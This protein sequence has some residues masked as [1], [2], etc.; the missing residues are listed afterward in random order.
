MIANIS[1]AAQPRVPVLPAQV[2]RVGPLLAPAAPPAADALRVVAPGLVAGEF[3]DDGEE[4]RGAAWGL[5]TIAHG[6]VGF[7]V[8]VVPRVVAAA[9]TGD[10]A[11]TH[12]G[13][14]MV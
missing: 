11:F 9:V 14:C 3:V 10:F 8:G 6:G 13:T 12:F 1:L 5:G 4:V 7:A 2:P